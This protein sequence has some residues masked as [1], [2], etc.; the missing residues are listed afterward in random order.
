MQLTYSNDGYWWILDKKSGNADLYFF[1]VGQDK[2]VS[3]DLKCLNT[4][5]TSL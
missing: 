4:H 2:E 1:V 3:S 5:V